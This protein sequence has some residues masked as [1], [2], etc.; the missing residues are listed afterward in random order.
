MTIARVTDTSTRAEIEAAITALR[1]KAERM[2][3]HWEDRR[4]EVADAIDELVD[5]WL[6][7]G[8]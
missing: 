1:A 5:R 8:S 7:A 6:I 3:A 4:A 2:P